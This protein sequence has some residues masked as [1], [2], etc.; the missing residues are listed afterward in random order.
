M[1]QHVWTEGFTHLTSLISQAELS[2]AL[3]GRKSSSPGSSRINKTILTHLPGVAMDRLRGIS[4]AALSVG[5]F[6]DCFK[7]A[8]MKLILKPGKGLTNPESYRP[9][10]LLGAG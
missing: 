10:S 8:E 4:N 3:K 6:P 9:I 7:A 2:S 1:T 5:Y